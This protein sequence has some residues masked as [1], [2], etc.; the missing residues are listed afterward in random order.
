MTSFPVSKRLF[1][2]AAMGCL[3]AALPLMLGACGLHMIKKDSKAPLAVKPGKAV[4]VIMRTGS[5]YGDSDIKNYLDG[6]YIG[7]NKDNC[8][9]MTDVKP[10]AHY[11]TA[12]GGN[13]DT[14]R[15]NFEAGRIYFL[16]QGVVPGIFRSFTRYFPMTLQE[17][18][19]EAQEIDYVVYDTQH[20]G[21]DLSQEDFEKEKK[22]FNE[23]VKKDPSHRRDVAQYT[24]F[25]RVK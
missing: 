19:H 10:G 20:P 18:L 4:L 13:K 6:K 3:L 23:E 22:D 25:N 16:R 21:K 9:F 11:V 24:G 2:K 17:A 7:G 15:M 14:V 5:F 8:Y 12:D 1:M